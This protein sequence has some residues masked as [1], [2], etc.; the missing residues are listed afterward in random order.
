VAGVTQRLDGMSV[1]DPECLSRSV[2]EHATGRWG[3]VTLAALADGPL[4][5]THLR[6]A[7]TGISDRMLTQTLHRLL[8][9]GLVQ[10]TV[11]PTVP[12]RVDYE[13][14]AV[15]RPIAERICGLIEAIYEQV[16]AIVAHQRARHAGLA[17][18]QSP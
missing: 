13:L 1:F 12:P 7:V 15:G 10:R 8:A 3:A 9:D 11:T 14:T 4:R 17:P 2:L 5:F 18:P 6:A 16:P